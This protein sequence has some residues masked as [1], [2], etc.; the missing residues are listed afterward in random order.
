MGSRS[1]GGVSTPPT[2][3]VP[4]EDEPRRESLSAGWVRY[5]LLAQALLCAV[6][7]ALLWGG[8]P[9][10]LAFAVVA[11]AAGLVS[12]GLGIALHGRPQHTRRPTL[13][14]AAVMIPLQIAL[15]VVAA[16]PPVGAAF[17]AVVVALLRPRFGRLGP[18]ARKVW[19]TLHVGFSVGWLGAAMAMLVLAVL[20]AVTADLAL[21]HHA[22]AIMHV[23][24][25]AIV[26][27]LVVLSLVTGLVVSL[28]TKWG[29]VRYRWV[30][31]KFVI[32]LS[33]PV[34][35]GIQESAWVRAA[36]SETAAD[37]AAD[38]AGTDVRLWVCFVVFSLLLWVA[39][40]LSTVKP[41]GRT[42]WGAGRPAI[43]R[44]RTGRRRASSRGH[45]GTGRTLRD[46]VSGRGR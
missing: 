40:A 7:V 12:V 41:W 23:F 22:Y 29:L 5:V 27:P 18:R 15:G 11:V 20:G 26:I 43:S 13:W 8:G 24:D 25:L 46:H 28:G 31:T 38:L 37:R 14:F 45:P 17:A 21:R 32:A 6:T 34:Y 35:A 3:T 4:K 39:T 44:A 9:V 36:V 19:L 2:A 16:L 30:L 1:R 10:E 33:I 42:R